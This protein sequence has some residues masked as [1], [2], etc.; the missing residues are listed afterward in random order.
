MKLLSKNQIKITKK[1]ISEILKNWKI[2]DFKMSELKGGIENTSLK[3]KT[4]DRVYVLRIYKQANDK[5]EITIKSEL[6]FMNF[7]FNKGLPVPKIFKN[8]KSSFLSKT[9][10]LNKTW[11]SMLMNFVPGGHVDEYNKKTV[12]NLAKIMAKLHLASI[13]YSAKSKKKFKFKKY[14]NEFVKKI[15]IDRL[16]DKKVKEFIERSKMHIFEYKNL[17][18]AIIHADLTSDNFLVLN[19]DIE[20]IIDFDDMYFGY[21]ISDIA[22]TGRDIL[23]RGN[24]NLL[25]S[26]L[27]SYQTIRKISKNEMC[28]LKNIMHARNYFVGPVL[29]Y[30]HGE[31]SFQ[32]KIA[33]DTEKKIDKFDF[34]KG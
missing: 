23:C 20:A 12:C 5:N 27:E 19:N 26:F 9:K 1:N 10:I 29:I 28:M 2:F 15:K 31:N 8:Y 6:D 24:G 34:K 30:M 14:E 18:S 16:K 25:K 21:V 17:P 3:I 33:L 13:E 4:S 11:Y 22:I 32:M 7:L